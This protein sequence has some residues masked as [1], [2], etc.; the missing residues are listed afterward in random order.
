MHLYFELRHWCITY[1]EEA[2]EQQ[3]H[4]ALSG[5]VS[6]IYSNSPVPAFVYYKS[7]RTRRFF[8]FY[9]LIND[10]IRAVYNAACVYV[11]R[12]FVVSFDVPNTSFALGASLQ[13]YK[14]A[15]NYYPRHACAGWQVISPPRGSLMC[16]K[17]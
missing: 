4:N 1:L 7:K 12:L 16:I 8:L 10:E 13:M 3:Q 6:N 9:Q 14:N 17:T 2:P 15:L 5:A 11:R